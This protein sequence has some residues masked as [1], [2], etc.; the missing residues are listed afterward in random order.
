[1]FYKVVM[2]A[3]LVSTDPLLLGSFRVRFLGASGHSTVTNWSAENL[4]W[5]V[6]LFPGTLLG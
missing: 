2:N 4:V 5:K 1:M 6:S 3:E